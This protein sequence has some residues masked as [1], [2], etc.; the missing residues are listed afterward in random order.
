MELKAG[1]MYQPA[2]DLLVFVGCIVVEDE[3]NLQ[4]AE[5]LGI[6]EKER[7]KVLSRRG[8]VVARAKVTEASP[9]GVI[10]MTFHFAESPVNMLTNQALDPASKI[11]EYKVCA[12]RVEKLA[13][14]AN[15]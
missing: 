6:A 10:R 9:P 13:E 7:I 12:V 15:V 14:T 5:T 3:M 2:A 4:D 8:A 11:P 1:M